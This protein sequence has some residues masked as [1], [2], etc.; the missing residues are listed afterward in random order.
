MRKILFALLAVVSIALQSEA[1]ERVLAVNPVVITGQLIKTTGPLRDFRLP[2]GYNPKIVRDLEGIIGKDEDLEEGPKDRKF[3]S[4]QHFSEDPSLQKVYPG[5]PHHANTEARAIVQ[6]FNGQPYQPLNP[7]DPTMCCGPNH[8]IQM[9][10]GASGALFKVYNKTGGQVV[11]QTYLNAITGKGGLGDPICLYDQQADRFVLTEFADKT[12]TGSEGLIFAVSQ[13]NDPSGSWYIYFFSTGTTF[14]DYPKYSVWSDAYYATTNDFANGSTYSGSS[15]YAFDKTKMIAGNQTATMQKFTL[16]STNKNFSAAPVNWEGSSTPPAGSGGLFAFMNDD[17]WSGSATDSIGLFEFKVNF[18]TPASTVVLQKSSLAVT[19]ATTDICTA[20]RGQ[21]IAQPGTSTAVEDLDSRVMNQPIYRN[22]GTYEGIVLTY[23]VNKGSSI[24]APRWYELRKTGTTW[25]VYQQ[26]TYSPDN[27]H[28]WMPSICYDAAGNIGLVYNVSSSTVYPGISYTG[29]KQCDALNTM[30]YAE[31]SIVA[32][33][34]SNGSTRYGDYNHVVCDPDGV[35]FWVT[36]EYNAAS[37]WSTRIAS[38]TLDNCSSCGSPA[39]PVT[40][41]ITANTATVGWTAISGANNYDV[42]YQL[43]GASAW[44]NAATATTAVSVNLSAL[45]PNS[46]YNWRVR[47]NCTAGSSAYVQSTFTTSLACSAV[48]GLASSSITSSSASV[49]WTAV[50]SALNYDVDYQITGAATW[51]NA[52]T[53]TT[54]TT[55]SLSGLSASTGYSWRVRANCTAG[56]GAYTSAAFSTLSLCGATSGL[57]SSSITI[58]SASVSWATVTSALNYDVDYQVTGAATWANAAT[59]TTSLSVSLSGLGAGTAYSWRVR[60]NC[61]AGA[62]AYST[63][64]FTTLSPCGTVSGL[65]GSAITASSATVSWT[66]LSGANNYDVD[67]QATGGATWTNAATATTATSVSLSGLT[68]S[69]A[70]TWRVRGNC[71]SGAGAY[72]SASF[73]TTGLTY[74]TSVGGTLDGVTNVTFNTI[75][76]S[77]SGTAAGYTDYSATQS[78]NVTIGNSYTISVKINTGGNYTNYAKAWIDW[79]RDGVFS[80]TTEEYNLGTAVN[81]TNG[82]TSL[83]PLTITVPAGAAIGTTRMRVS[84]QYNAAP[85]SCNAS[86]DGEVEDYSIVVAAGNPCA[87]PAGLAV[88]AIA[89]SSATFGWTAVTGATG[90]NVQYRITGTTVWTAGTA[91][92]NS[93]SATGLAAGSNYE[94][95]VQ[96][97]CSITSTSAFSASVNFSTTGG[98][99]TAIGLAASAITT[100]S[101]T[102][103]WT[104]VTGATGYSLQWKLSS[105]SVWTTVSGLTTNSYALAGL[106][107]ASAYQFQVST[108]CGTSSSSYSSPLSFSTLSGTVTYCTSSGTTT[109]EYIKTTVLGTINHTVGNDGGYGNYSTLSTGLTAG[110]AYSIKITPGFASGSYTEYYTVYID[111]NQDGTLNGT[112]EAVATG[113]GTGTGAKS[114]TFT[115]PTTA[116]NGPTRIR[117]QMKYGSASTNPCGTLTYGD[118]H[119]YTVSISGGTGA[120]VQNGF[121]LVNPSDEKL[122]GFLKLWPNPT[123]GGSTNV[124]YQLAKEALAT[125]K[126]VDL[127]GRTL[128][129]VSLGKQSAGSHNFIMNSVK[130]LKRGNYVAILYQND[131]VIGRTKLIVLN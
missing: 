35:T 59:G 64:S 102:L 42:D 100:T 23:V 82:A 39:S 3:P 103:G 22:F 131:E 107:A 95:Q 76:N 120:P 93:F 18:T 44:T 54:S 14:P 8:I 45:T 41:A 48:A 55:A 62:G 17:T 112:G 52:V 7:P 10:N 75:N 86:F 123:E 117:V 20:T 58:N 34:A 43:N 114:L 46:A 49:S 13:T 51:T 74:C 65:S 81:V 104:A 105:A 116:K 118:V 98:C 29:R 106:T 88:S 30:T 31:N 69:T 67:Y 72:A 1:Q 26:S 130:Q 40:S 129:T 71:T 27:T 57:T 90:Y 33:T 36:G 119:D 96:T 99:G 53:G 6:N 89:N 61:T 77:T 84:T 110:T 127:S 37:T 97:V 38:F 80:T 113:S 25:S 2:A 128:Q 11:A 9:I 79:N 126:V 94:V 21:C 24:A 47:A 87:T 111:Y 28:R 50:T 83:S 92:S 5:N 122:I 124:T 85:T 12:Q 66:A 121:T 101:A 109:Y 68:L 108:V 60:A 19:A 73:T 125:I 32:G 70:Y 78:T 16:G 115:V 56:A 4:T 63:A 15:V 91:S